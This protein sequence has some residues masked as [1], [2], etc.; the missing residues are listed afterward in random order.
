M[1]N[2]HPRRPTD[3]HN[4][5]ARER[6]DTHVTNM[7]MFLL[8]SCHTKLMYIACSGCRAYAS[9]VPPLLG[10]CSVIFVGSL[11]LGNF[12]IGLLKS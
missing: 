8:F 5:G 11:K 2:P 9:D 12:C 10:E 4:E 7:T 3:A 6:T 1:P